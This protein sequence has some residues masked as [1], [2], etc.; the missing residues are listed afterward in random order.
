MSSILRRIWE[1]PVNE[2]IFSQIK[3]IVATINNKQD[4]VEKVTP[5][6]EWIN[7][8]F[9]SL[10]AIDFIIAIEDMF[11]FEVLDEDLLAQKE[12]LRTLGSIVN[13]I[14]KQRADE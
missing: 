8:G 13:Y 12:W 11:G 9:D 3:E 4:M 5:D 6:T 10:Q 14:E 1:R 7:L 2:I